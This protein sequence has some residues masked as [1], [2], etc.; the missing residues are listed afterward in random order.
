MRRRLSAVLAICALTGCSFPTAG[1]DPAGPSS[2]AASSIAPSASAS[3]PVGLG[4]AIRTE[5]SRARIVAERPKVPGYRRAQF[6]DTWTDKHNGLGGHNKCR[7]RD[8]VLAAQLTAVQRRAGSRC[9]VESGK[10]ADPYTGCTILFQRTQPAQVQKKDRQC[11]AHVTTVQ[12]DHVYPLARA[13]DLG[14]STW[15]MQRRTDF[16]ND[17]A[18]NLL[19]VDGAVNAGKGDD[20]PG[21]W[22]PVFQAARCPYVLRYL[23]VAHAWGL[24]ITA[25]DRDA[26]RLISKTCP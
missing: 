2:T 5:L 9:V 25:G 8:D 18:M 21:E 26:A 20:G 4:A 1:A 16:A 6:G 22:M 11:T 13:W 19:A 17:E 10:L 7:T 12:I 14:A 3:A 15:S 24:A 23:R